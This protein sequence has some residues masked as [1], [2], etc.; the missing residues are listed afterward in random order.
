MALLL[1]DIDGTL[2]RPLGIGRRAFERALLERYGRVP[3]QR[4]PYDGMLDPQIAARTLDLLGVAPTPAETGAL[5]ARYV[6]LLAEERPA[7]VRDGLCA[8][9]PELLEEAAARG[10]HLGLLTGNVRLGAKIK[11]ALFGLDR[12]FEEGGRLVG[13]FGDDAPTRADLVPIAAGRCSTAFGSPFP[14]EATWL[15][16]DSPR[17]VEAAKGSGAHCV[18]VATGWCALEDLASL[19]PDLTLPDLAVAAPLW[20]ALEGAAS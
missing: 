20:N 11:L 7:D 3:E 1:F 5:L 2:I 14:V 15:V 9:L 18:A 4:F 10:H 17:D 13:A 16:G 6:E 19:Q 8:G 12:Y